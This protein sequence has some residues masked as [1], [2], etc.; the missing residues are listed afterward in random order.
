MV[1]ALLAAIAWAQPSEHLLL[2]GV[3]CAHCHE[4]PHGE[5]K[6]HCSRCHSTGE[7]TP[8]TVTV[9]DHA[10]LV[11]PLEGLHAQVACDACH[12]D[13]VLS[14]LPRECSGCHLD[15]HRGRLGTDCGS[16]HQV[17]GWTPVEDFD[18]MER[19]GFALTGSHDGPSCDDCHDG[20]RGAAMRV[21]QEVSCATCHPP[22]HG[23]F[24]GRDCTSCHAEGATDFTQ[25]PLFDHHQTSFSLERRHRTQSCTSCHPVG[26][27]PIPRCASCHIDPHGGEMTLQCADC[28]RE[29]RW[30]LAR[31]DHDAT[32]WPL[33]GRHYVT[34]CGSCHTNQR[35]IG[36]P[37]DCQDC[38]AL[39]A[40]QGP[41]SVLAHVIPMTCSDCH[42]TTW[43]WSL[44]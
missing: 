23:P 25:V 33:R 40:A 29:D 13:A 5:H 21:T 44:P 24:G 8:S 15:R 42:T 19:T 35:W 39:D 1:A 16:C 7:W 10:G 2:L 3:D 11:F 9:Q 37:Q 14:P 34:P 4:D 6:R 12:L 43:T 32:G 26:A 20:A 17:T 41:P 22:V 30:R 36:L 31:F 28:H 27:D 38:H 18:H